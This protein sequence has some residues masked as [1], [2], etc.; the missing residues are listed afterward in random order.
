[1]AI[2]LLSGVA[3]VQAPVKM[4]KAEYP[5][6]PFGTKDIGCGRIYL[7]V[8]DEKDRW[9]GA[10]CSEIA[11]RLSE[12][13]DVREVMYS[14]EP[15]PIDMLTYSQ[16][17]DYFEISP[18]DFEQAKVNC[19]KILSEGYAH[20]DILR[21]C[22][23]TVKGVVPY[24][25]H[26]KVRGAD[27][28]DWA[29]SEKRQATWKDEVRWKILSH[30]ETMYPEAWKA[31]GS[32]GQK[33]LN[34]TIERELDRAALGSGKEWMSDKRCKLTAAK[35]SHMRLKRQQGMKLKELAKFFRISISQ[36]AQIVNGKSWKDVAPAICRNC[37]QPI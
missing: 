35:V 8:W 5:S 26:L 36:V 23:Q 32:S 31:L 2:F 30:I 7:Q 33:S 18:K 11:K 14:E 4:I 25:L 9:H 10:T 17:Q 24:G 27:W 34:N 29:M 16:Y 28:E 12:M 21:Q 22:R 19:S 3:Q 13:R 6:H 20:P 1:M 37:G 15:S